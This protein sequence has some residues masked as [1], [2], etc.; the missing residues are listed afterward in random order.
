MS[1]DLVKPDVNRMWGCMFAGDL[2]IQ[3]VKKKGIL[4]VGDTRTGKSTLFNHL[5]K[6]PMEG[7]KI[8]RRDVQ[9]QIIF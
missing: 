5:L 7:V 4:I 9:L 3:E 8:N 6:V 1:K 2:A